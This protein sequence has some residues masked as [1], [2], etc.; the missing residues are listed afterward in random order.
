MVEWGRV[1]WS[2]WA[3]V[4]LAIGDLAVVL[5]MRSISAA[6]LIFFIVFIFVWN[7]FLLRAVRWLWFATVALFALVLTIELITASGS[8]HG[9]AIGFIQLGLLLL[10]ATRRFFGVVREAPS[11]EAG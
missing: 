7:Y 8:W 2:L 6:P 9:T 3:Y 11:A 4:V 10:P 5:L 1:P